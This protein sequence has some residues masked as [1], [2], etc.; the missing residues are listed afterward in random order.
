MANLNPKRIVQVAGFGAR[1]ML[2]AIII[3]IG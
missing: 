2:D 3:L 1:V